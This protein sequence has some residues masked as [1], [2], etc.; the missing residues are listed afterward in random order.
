M[1]YD[2]LEE[3]YHKT[4][5]LYVATFKRVSTQYNNVISMPQRYFNVECLFICLSLKHA[6][7]LIVYVEMN[8]LDLID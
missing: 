2:A 3:R 1:T 6:H 4:R 8:V 5:V 7:S